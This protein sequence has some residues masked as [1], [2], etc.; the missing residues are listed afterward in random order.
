MDFLTFFGL[1]EDPF[2][3]TPDPAYFYPSSSHNEGLLLMDYSI[4]QKEGFLLIIG[5]PG[6]GKTTLLK[7]F[8]EKW[9][10]S[11]EI[12]IVLTPRLSPQDFLM[13]VAEDFN[14]NLENKNKNDIIKALRDFMMQQ[15][16]GNKRVIIIVDE[17]QNL[18]DETLE[19]LRLLSNLETDKDKLLQIIL[20]GQPELE[21]K[22]TSDSLRQ[23]NQRIVTRVHLQHFNHEE[24]RDYINFRLI[25][26]GKENLKVHSKAVKSIY[27]YTNG[28][29]RLINML[30]SRALM[31]AYLEESNTILHKHIQ[32]AIKSLN[33]SDMKLRERSTLVAV[34]SCAAALFVISVAT[35]LY[36]SN[37]GKTG[38]TAAVNMNNSAAKI[39]ASVNNSSENAGG[40]AERKRPLPDSNMNNAAV[41]PDEDIEVY[42]YTVPHKMISVTVDI[43]HIRNN[44]SL[45][46]DKIG[47]TQRGNQLTVLSEATDDD[48]ARWYLIPYKG[49]KH[50]I[51][52]E[53]VE[54]IKQ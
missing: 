6:T 50:W 47:W 13:S 54:V 24:T 31:A 16:V 25:K 46:A 37:A 49:E 11:A 45:Y 7:V 30:I 38:E 44:P 9:K 22:L 10:E 51:S 43:A 20:L 32:N 18:P 42:T 12:A 17:A 34:V 35:F 28:V 33:H 26:A 1:K 36:I 5:D 29:P 48:N 15:Y 4:D 23:L 39:V 41:Q 40:D 19:E 21:S 27:N 53:V 8:I 2:K 52:A 3:L 14:I